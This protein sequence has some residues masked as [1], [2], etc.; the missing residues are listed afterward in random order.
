MT[1][2]LEQAG[3]H[4]DP[5]APVQ[6]VVTDDYLRPELAA[7]NRTALLRKTPW[8]LVKPIGTKPLL[9]PV[10]QP[11]AGPCWECLAFW[12]RNNRPVEELVR[13]HRS[14]DAI[15]PPPHGTP[16]SE[17]PRRTRPRRPRNRSR[18]CQPRP[19]A[20]PLFPSPP[21]RPR[22]FPHHRARRRPAPPVPYL[23]RPHPHGRHRRAPRSL[24]PRRRPT[25][26]TAATAARFPDRTVRALQAPSSAR[27]RARHAPRTAARARHRAPRRVRL[28][29]P[30]LPPRRHP[31]DQRLRQ[32]LRGQGPRRRAGQGQRPLRGPRTRERRLPGG[33]SA[34]PGASR[35]RRAAL[36]PGDL[37]NFSE[38]Q[39]LG[40]DPRVSPAEDARRWV[41]EILD[42]ATPIDWTPA[43]S[44][45]K[46]ERRYVPLPHCYAEAPPESGTTFCR[47]NGNG[48]AAGTCLE[49]ALLQ[50]L[51][52]LV[53]RDAAA[54]WWYNRT[55]RPASTW[56]AS[57][58]LTSPPFGPTMRAW[59]GPSGRSTSPTTS[60]SPRASRSPTKRRRT[61]SPS[62]LAATSTRA[63]P[64][65]GR[66]PRSTSSSSPPAPVGPRGPR[67]APLSRIPLS[68]PR[69]PSGP[70][71]GHAP[72]RRRRLAHRHRAVHAPSS[73]RRPGARGGR[74]NPP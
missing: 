16:R 51:L 3:V 37:L 71:R 18:P 67:S 7:I 63:S 40:R 26:M 4:V 34:R 45:S 35:D 64:Y 50:G 21:P 22:H 32:G 2:A 52:E 12:M 70:A 60:A 33:R 24:S 59:A 68:P 31:A 42:A 13:R 38:A 30:R 28:R 29:L 55:P 8:C 39:Y 61:A 11:D 69:P 6:I 56:T 65:S 43:W 47:A 36:P 44:L 62:G 73:R 41:P 27:S 74:Q 5:D 14:H 25:S 19:L 46:N 10:F 72:P 17:R 23:R 1:D 48:V 9:G 53:E 49:E 54:I 57:G 20:P 58:N 66:S 15:L